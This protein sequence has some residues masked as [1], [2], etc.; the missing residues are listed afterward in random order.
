MTP[1]TNDTTETSDTEPLIRLEPGGRAPILSYNLPQ[2]AI[3]FGDN[4]IEFEYDEDIFTE[5]AWK[6]PDESRY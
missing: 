2:P 6:R 3:Y 1:D 4:F 5:V